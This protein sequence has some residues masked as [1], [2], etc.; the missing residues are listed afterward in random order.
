MTER[1]QR[2]DL[3]AFAFAYGHQGL[4]P[5]ALA[6][7]LDVAWLTWRLGE[8]SLGEVGLFLSDPQLHGFW[9]PRAVSCLP[10]DSGLWDTTPPPLV[11]FFTI[12]L[13]KNF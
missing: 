12:S 1:G 4:L 10:M 5:R 13:L 2:G 6:M 11:K 3:I 9:I 7:G 8:K